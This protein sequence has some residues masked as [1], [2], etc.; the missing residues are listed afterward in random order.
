MRVRRSSRDE[1]SA[2][3]HEKLELALAHGESIGRAAIPAPPISGRRND[4]YTGSPNGTQGHAQ[5]DRE[6]HWMRPR[7]RPS[8]SGDERHHRVPLTGIVNSARGGHGQRT[9]GCDEFPLRIQRGT[10]GERRLSSSAVI[11]VAQKCQV[12]LF[13]RADHDPARRRPR[14]GPRT[15]RRRPGSPPPRRRRRRSRCPR[16]RRIC[17]GSAPRP[18]GGD[19]VRVGVR[20]GAGHLVARDGQGEVLGAERVDDLVDDAPVRGGDQ[21]GG[22]A[23]RGELGRAAGRRPGISGTP[24]ADARPRSGR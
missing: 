6:Q 23:V 5:G 11:S 19:Q 18:A 15:A 12:D 13:E 21:G 1:I 24:A 20:L 22:D 9:R 4:S 17:A 16:R 2:A 14:W 10:L 3:A 8:T 7:C